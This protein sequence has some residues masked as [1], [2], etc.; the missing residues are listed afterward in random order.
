MSCIRLQKA[1][2]STF[3]AKIS[4]ELNSKTYKERVC[5]EQLFVAYVLTPQQRE[6]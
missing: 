1:K 4:I 3:L 5:A 6:S 2:Y